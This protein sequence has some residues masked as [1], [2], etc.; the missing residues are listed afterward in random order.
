MFNT[1]DHSAGLNESSI[2]YVGR[3]RWRYNAAGYIYTLHR[4]YNCAIAIYWCLTFYDTSSIHVAYV[5]SGDWFKIHTAFCTCWLF[6]S[7]F[8]LGAVSG[9][10]LQST[11]C[12]SAYIAPRYRPGTIVRARWHYSCSVTVGVCWELNTHYFDNLTRCSDYSC[13]TLHYTNVM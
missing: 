1:N 9:R 10:R 13:W 6:I 12:Q 8:R 11:Y 4:G 5:I 7:L 2:V 3:R